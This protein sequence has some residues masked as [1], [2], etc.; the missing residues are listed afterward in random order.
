MTYDLPDLHLA[1]WPQWA[2]RRRAW[3]ALAEDCLY[4]H[5][6]EG[7]SVRGEV[8]DTERLWEGRGR[9][10]TVRVHYGP[11]LSLAFL[12]EVY[13]PDAPG[14]HPAITWNQ[15]GAGAFDCC[16]YEQAVAE[17]GY[18]IARFDREQVAHDE[19]PGTRAVYDAYP[20]YDWGAIRAWA[21]AQSRLA[22]Y[23]LQGRTRIPPGCAAR[24]SPGVAR[25]RWRRASS[26]S[27]SASA[28][29][30]APGRGAA[31]AS[32]TWGTGRA[33]ART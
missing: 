24:G 2:E 17:R 4:G 29:P 6:P 20:G 14:R 10:E 32:A 12:E 1:P 19:R 27:G 30:S 23:L 9:R 26:T 5:A 15:F 31:A 22:D 25:W 11:G 18:M 16:P 13:V 28:R 33:S 21:W 8:I 3:V 7:G